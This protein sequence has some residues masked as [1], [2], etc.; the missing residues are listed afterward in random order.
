[1]TQHPSAEHEVAPLSPF[2]IFM[3]YFIRS[4]LDGLVPQILHLLCYFGLYLPDGIILFLFLLAVDVQVRII[5]RPREVASSIPDFTPGVTMNVL[6]P[7][8]CKTLEPENEDW[9]WGVHRNGH[10]LKETSVAVRGR[11]RRTGLVATFPSTAGRSRVWVAK[12]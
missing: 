7:E 2:E 10:G 3:F 12:E 5:S 8:Y 9:E 11:P 1:M 6:V 4:T